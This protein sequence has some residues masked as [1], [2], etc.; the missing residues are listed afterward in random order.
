MFILWPFSNFNRLSK[1]PATRGGHCQRTPANLGPAVIHSQPGLIARAAML[2]SSLGLV[3]L[4]HWHN[5]VP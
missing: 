4:E 5:P 3:G 1:H 2:K